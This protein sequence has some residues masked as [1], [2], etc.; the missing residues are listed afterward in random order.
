MVDPGTT[1]GDLQ[2]DRHLANG[3]DE[4]VVIPQELTGGADEVGLLRTSVGMK[5]TFVRMKVDPLQ[6]GG[7]Y[8]QA[9]DG[10]SLFGCGVDEDAIHSILHVKVVEERGLF[11]RKQ[12]VRDH[13]V[14]TVGSARFEQCTERQTNV[15][16]RRE[17]GV[18]AIS[19]TKTEVGHGGRGARCTASHRRQHGTRAFD[20]A[21][22]D[23]VRP[24]LRCDLE[25]VEARLPSF[26]N[27]RPCGIPEASSRENQCPHFWFDPFSLLP[28][29]SATRSIVGA[30]ISPLSITA[31]DFSLPDRSSER[32]LR[33]LKLTGQ[34]DSRFGEA[35]LAGPC[36]WFF[37][38]ARF[39]RPRRML[40]W[41]KGQIC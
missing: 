16:A 20:I 34:A 7:R 6:L 1:C 30:A 12:G 4:A 24:E 27:G 8:P 22:V 19:S 35:W 9:F 3:F 32:L 11:T 39:R 2:A 23:D 41:I 15:F 21:I 37:S 33:P 31:A 29:I 5:E 25:N 28:Q 17:D 18:V 13:R 40:R 26:G 36:G 14:R 10:V 38:N